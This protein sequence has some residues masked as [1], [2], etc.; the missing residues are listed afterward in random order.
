M[1][2]CR[3]RG[4]RFYIVSMVC[5]VII[6]I[7]IE[8]A[9]CQ[10]QAQSSPA[11]ESAIVTFTFVRDGQL[12]GYLKR[13]DLPR[14][15]A[16]TVFE[17]KGRTWIPTKYGSRLTLESDANGDA[18]GVLE[19]PLGKYRLVDRSTCKLGISC[20]QEFIVSG[21]DRGRTQR[22]K[23]VY[24]A[25]SLTKCVLTVKTESDDGISIRTSPSVILPREDSKRYKYRSERKLLVKSGEPVTFYVWPETQKVRFSVGKYYYLN[26]VGLPQRIT[27]SVTNLVKGAHWNPK[28]RQA[29]ATLTVLMQTK[30]GARPLTKEC[31]E[32]EYPDKRVLGLLYPLLEVRDDGKVL[33]KTQD[34]GDFDWESGRLSYTKLA[35]DRTYVFPRFVRAGEMRLLVLKGAGTRVKLGSSTSTTSSDG[36][37]PSLGTIV[38]GSRKSHKW[39][40]RG[41]VTDT[42]GNPLSQA[43]VILVDGYGYREIASTDKNG[44]YSITA[45]EGRYK[46][47]LVKGGFYPQTEAIE[48]SEDS[49]ANRAL[50]RLPSLTVFVPGIKRSGGRLM[51]TL[52]NG[53]RGSGAK[54]SGPARDEEQVVFADLPRGE[55][56][57]CAWYYPKNIVQLANVVPSAQRMWVSK[58]TVED[59]QKNEVVARLAEPRRITLNLTP[60]LTNDNSLIILWYRWRDSYLPVIAAQAGTAK[61]VRCVVPVAGEYVA[62][63]V[64]KLKA[65]RGDDVWK[66]GQ[67]VYSRPFRIQK[68]DTEVECV[69]VAESKHPFQGWIQPDARILDRKETE[70][71]QEGGK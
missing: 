49:D 52:L 9:A 17:R 70:A 59:A 3:S 8:C 11:S 21:D 48:L 13:S 33:Y 31:W 57:V 28:R 66:G 38:I 62:E 56:L 20:E 5:V 26:A 53:I 30:T 71:W 67:A 50:K 43:S 7:L 22:V 14:R 39:T 60:K 6:G 58:V 23:L 46:M 63:I 16:W 65:R 10:V 41:T 55:Y 51:V 61:S 44:R 4:P 24:K 64:Q 54:R 42:V 40:V 19:I 29:V 12:K 32:A 34:G 36:A 15:L 1:N 2:M 68:E 37:I 18:I 25:L 47:M 69:F 35:P 27:L 45:V